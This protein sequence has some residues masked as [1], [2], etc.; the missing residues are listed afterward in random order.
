MP[1]IGAGLLAV[2]RCH[3]PRRTFASGPG[4]RKYT[5]AKARV[6]KSVPGWSERLVADFDELWNWG[7]WRYCEEMKIKCGESCVDDFEASPH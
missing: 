7:D 1:L 4:L 6:V 3:T 2:L 5:A